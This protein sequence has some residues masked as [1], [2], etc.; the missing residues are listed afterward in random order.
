MTMAEV[1]RRIEDVMVEAYEEAS[2]ATGAEVVG[3]TDAPAASTRGPR[4]VGDS[5]AGRQEADA[6]S[7]SEEAA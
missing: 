1:V 7:G 5:L 6:A 4:S 2:A 3:S